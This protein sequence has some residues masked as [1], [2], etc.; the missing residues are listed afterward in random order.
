[1]VTLNIKINPILKYK[2][3][4]ANRFQTMTAILTNEIIK[5][6]ENFEKQY[7]VIPVTTDND[8]LYLFIKKT[9]WLNIKKE[10]FMKLYWPHIRDPFK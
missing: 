8:E 3:Q 4:R 5:I 1:M 2:F 6:V 10:D 9:Y 7:W